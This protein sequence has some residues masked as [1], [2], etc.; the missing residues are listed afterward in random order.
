MSGL[1]F[2]PRQLGV[3]RLVRGV[4][5][6]R[7][8]DAVQEVGDTSDPF[9]REGHLVDDVVAALH[10]VANASYPLLER[11]IRVASGHLVDRAALVLQ[12][13]KAVALV[14]LRPSRPAARRAN[15]WAVRAT[16][17][18]ARVGLISK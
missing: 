11:L 6:L 7:V 17:E 4:A 12:L 9:V 3:D 16:C 1:A 13:L 8:V 15:P 18:D 10:R 14:R 5:G 2:G